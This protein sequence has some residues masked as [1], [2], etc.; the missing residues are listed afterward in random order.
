M[1][2]LGTKWP[3]IT[4]T[5]NQSAPACSTARTSSPS[6]VKSAERREAETR[7]S[8]FLFMLLLPSLP[9]RRPRPSEKSALARRYPHCSAL[10]VSILVLSEFRP[11]RSQLCPF[12]SVATF[13]TESVL[14]LIH[15][16]AVPHPLDEEATAAGAVCVFARVHRHIACIYI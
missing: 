6:L 9:G 7:I 13:G 12:Y 8:S 11:L 1:V 5:C 14:Y 3:S 2:I 16:N 4:S 15:P 10:N